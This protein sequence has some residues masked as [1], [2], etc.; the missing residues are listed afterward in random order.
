MVSKDRGGQRL[1]RILCGFFLDIWTIQVG[2]EKKLLCH[3]PE[4]HFGVSKTVFF[5]S[6]KGEGDQR[7]A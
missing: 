5:N 1:M 7:Q 6:H 4:V 2:D 3:L